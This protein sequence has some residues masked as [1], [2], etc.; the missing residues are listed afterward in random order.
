LTFDGQGRLVDVGSQTDPGTGRAQ[1]MRISRDSS[2]TATDTVVIP[3]PPADRLGIV[4]VT[5][6]LESGAAMFYLYQPY[7]PRHLHAHMPGGGWA[8]AL[9]SEY[10]IQWHLP[11]GRVITIQRPDQLGPELTSEERDRAEARI[12][13][14]AESGRPGPWR[15]PLRRAGT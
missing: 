9:S 11:T 15:Y 8:R 2:G 5:R 12:Q 3:E 10:R 13:S 14:D 1:I 7:G 6:R 4:T